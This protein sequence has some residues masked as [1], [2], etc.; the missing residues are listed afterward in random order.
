MTEIIKKY[1]KGDMV[2]IWQPANVFIPESAS[3]GKR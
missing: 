1:D 2:I 3:E